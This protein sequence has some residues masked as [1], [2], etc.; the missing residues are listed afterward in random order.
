M[1]RFIKSAL[2]ASMVVVA[3]FS[4]VGCGDTSSN[5]TKTE[6]TDTVDTTDDSSDKAEVKAMKGEELQ[7]LV[8]DNKAKDGVLVIDVRDAEEYEAG[9]IKHAIN[10]SSEEIES[11]LSDLEEY[12]ETPIILYCNTGNRSGKAAEL[13][14][15]N[16]FKDVTNAE[17]VKE[18]DYTLTEYGNITA[19]EFLK[20]AKDDNVQII[21]VRPSEDFEKGHL[22]GAINVPFDKVEENIDKVDKS[23]EQYVYCF[24]GNKSAEVTETLKEKGYDATNVLEGTKEYDYEIVE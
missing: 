18:Y 22:E 11:K 8:D 17:G 24:T 21:D 5:D 1:K 9:H 23:K 3:A 7:K 15:E 6:T 14:V 4:M 10:I 20:K 12:K 13:L 19:G 2:V 16:G